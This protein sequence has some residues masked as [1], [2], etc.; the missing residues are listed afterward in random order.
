MRSAS[1]QSGALRV[2]N[3]VEGFG[4][5]GGGVGWVYVCMYG[6]LHV[7]VCMHACMSGLCVC[8]CVCACICGLAGMCRHLG[9]SWRLG[10][11]QNQTPLL[12][13]RMGV[14]F[15][16]GA[17]KWPKPSPQSRLPLDWTPAFQFPMP[18][19]H[20]LHAPLAWEKKTGLPRTPRSKSPNQLS[21]CLGPDSTCL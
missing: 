14:C 21:K 9:G 3:R 15:G 13:S 19:F 4:A 1:L 18:T 5:V 17:G 2:L 6:G 8:V 11:G 7:C 10:N 20:I 12:G 16:A